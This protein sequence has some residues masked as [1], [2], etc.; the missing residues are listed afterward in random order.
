MCFSAIT[1][2]ANLALLQASQSMSAWFMQRSI[3]IASQA[4]KNSSIIVTYTVYHTQCMHLGNV[5]GKHN[6]MESG[7]CHLYIVCT[8]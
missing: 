2:K 4:P 3:I 6:L 5:P 7:W 8:V 1:R